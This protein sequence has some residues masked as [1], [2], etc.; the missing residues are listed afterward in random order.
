MTSV[1]AAT[2][3]TPP[4]SPAAEDADDSLLECLAI[5]TRLHGRPV[6]AEALRAGLPLEGHRLTPSVFVRAAEIQG[7]SAR[8]LKRAV[9]RISNLVLPAVLLF[10]DGKACVLT[11]MESAEAAE[12]IF[13]ETGIGAKTVTLTALSPLYSGYCILVQPKLRADA[14]TGD[15]SPPP[16]HSWFWGTLWRF[17]RYYLETMVGALMINVL[18]IA[19]SLFVMNVYDRVVPNNAESTL[20]VLAAGTA[21]AIGFEFVARTLR[22]YLLDIVGKKIDLLLA[23]QLFRQALGIRMEAR[24]ASAGAFAS[25]LREFEGLRDFFTSATLATITDLPFVFLFTWI[26]G[27]IGGPIGLVPLLAIPVLLVAGLLAQIPLARLMQRHLTESCA[28]HGILVEAVEGVETLKTLSAEGALQR[29]WENYTALTAQSAMRSRFISALV[30]NLAVLTQQAVTILMVIWGAYRIHE[31]LLT[32]GG[33]VACTILSS[34]ALAPLG[35]LA[36]LLTRYQQSRAALMALNRIMKLPTERPPGRSFLH[37]PVLSGRIELGHVNFSYP[38]AKLAVLH[39]VSFQVAAG[40]HV[41]ILGRV[42]SG[43]STTLKLMM[44]LYETTNGS[45]LIDGTELQ[46][47]DPADL[48]RNIG[49]VSQDVRLFYGTLRENIL[50][51]TPLAEDEAI[52]AAARIAGLDRLVATHPLGFDLRVGERGEGLSGGQK[53][54][55]ALARALLLAPPVFLLDEPTSSMD[56]NTEQAFIAHFKTFLKG[57]TLVLATHK[58]AMLELVERLI[59]LDAGKVVAD[60]PRDIV[61]QALTKGPQPK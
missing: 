41:A 16:T 51:G 8:V 52:L 3:P 7:Y 25:N 49:Y 23:S 27:L 21:I 34:R 1:Q 57:R 32:T 61:L 45:V 30:V 47:V 19:T 15:E 22:G 35:Q 29:R 11:R 55:V 43:K 58:P 10:K 9:R 59:V 2:H 31:G 33:L 40:E 4:P 60:G 36:T 38:Q 24:P 6:S 12:I 14:R 26:I 46:Q 13:P 50:L 5:L 37:R 18:T 17:K 42:G 56:H 48:R 53:Q 20:W 44:G 39:D 28:K 54:S